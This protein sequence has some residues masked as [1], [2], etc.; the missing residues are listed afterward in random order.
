MLG[1][2][3][4]SSVD[5]VGRITLKIVST[6]L[7]ARWLAPE[8]FGRASLTIVLVTV[9][10]ICVSAPFEEALSQRKIV[11]SRHFSSALVVVL[12]LSTLLCGLAMIVGW[13]IDFKSADTALIAGP[14]AVFSLILFAQGPI[15][16]FTALARRQRAFKRLALSNVCGE[17][18]GT[19][20]GLALAFFGAGVWSLLAVRLI[21]RFTVLAW[22]IAACPVRVRLRFSTAHLNDLKTFAGWFFGARLLAAAS[23]AAFQ[24]LV[25]R[26]FGLAGTGYLNMAV[27]IIDP[28]RGLVGSMGHNIAM[29]FFMRVQDAPARLR[30]SVEQTL[31][32]T[33]LF[34]LPLY[35][36]L[37]AAGPTIIA[38]L[39]GPEWV[40]SGHIVVCLAL[41]AA[42]LAPANFLRGAI[43][44]KG[45]AEL[46]FLSGLC[47]CVLMIAALLALS[48]W[49][50]I[51]IG[52]A[53]LVSFCGQA[54]FNTAAA[55]VVLGLATRR[56]LANVLPAMLSAGLMGLAVAAVGTL[57]A[58][59]A[60][61]LAR[62]GIQIMVGV[63]VYAALVLLFHRAGLRRVYQS[64]RA[65][66]GQQA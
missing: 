17:L 14:I 54:V 24:A 53:R 29:S 37:A 19:V 50:L 26:F 36:G 45:R 9:L 34:L 4:L 43:G 56:M 20:A 47:E 42:I 46:V 52:L 11:S 61:L 18:L 62:L 31:A 39:A 65:T 13:G 30:A 59:D 7:F 27:R 51:A 25:T 38:V 10:A 63:M 8:I 66:T 55:G 44:A 32:S 23:D 1:W 41:G 49:G 35:I 58:L 57:P 3:S 22:L 15:S 28:V 12:G 48:P 60:H 21:G 6:V 5:A 64:L 40:A 33:S 16:I 2:I